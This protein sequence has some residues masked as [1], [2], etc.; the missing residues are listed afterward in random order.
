M[1]GLIDDLMIGR[2]PGGTP[3]TLEYKFLVR[4]SIEIFGGTGVRDKHK[5]VTQIAS[6]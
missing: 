1:L 6:I 5:L 4:V 3:K 2:T